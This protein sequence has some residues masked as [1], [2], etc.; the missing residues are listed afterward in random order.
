MTDYAIEKATVII[1]DVKDALG[2][3]LTIANVASVTVIITD[4][5]G[6][7][8]QAEAAAAWDAATTSW[9]YDWGNAPGPGNYT[10]EVHINSVGGGR[11]GAEFIEFH[12]AASPVPVPT[13]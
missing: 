13:P 7:V 8:V 2:H 3:P 12:L 11:P 5:D 9:Y 4:A 6:N 10:A 1:S